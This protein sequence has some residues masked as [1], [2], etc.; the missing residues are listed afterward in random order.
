MRRLV[1]VLL[2]LI[3][4]GCSPIKPAV[5]IKNDLYIAAWYAAYA[6]NGYRTL[7]EYHWL[8]TEIN[9]VWYRL[10]QDYFAVGQPPFVPT[11]NA[12]QYKKEIAALARKH[13]IKLV[14]SI[15]NWGEDN[16]DDRVLAAII[17]D[18]EKRKKHV[19]EIV[20]LVMTNGYD[21]IDID[22]EALR[23][24]ARDAFSAF[25]AELGRALHAKDKLLSVAVYAKT[26]DATWDGAGAQD[27]EELA[28]YAD[29]LKVMGYDYHWSTHHPG[30]LAPLSWLEAV[31]DYAGEVARKV[32]G[33]KD[34]LIIGLPLYG[35]DWEVWSTPQNPGLAAKEVMYNKALQLQKEKK[36]EVKRDDTR[37]YPCNCGFSGNAEPYFVYYDHTGKKHI[38]YYQDA[39]ATRARLELIDRYRHLV[40]GI[41]FWRLGDEDPEIWREITAY[42]A[43]VRKIPE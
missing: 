39:A 29:S 31:L 8:F 36:S 20:D 6:P 21:G 19:Q 2:F 22:Y 33:L 15:Q 1:L 28:K 26:F 18:P 43:R 14:P 5:E 24:G 42:G 25:I 13:G 17:Q 37:Y 38:V 9:P 16:F 23:A 41:T 30:P 10:N 32:P 7:Q 11:Y 12:Q 35:L 34:K 40:K 3:I 4:A 27:W